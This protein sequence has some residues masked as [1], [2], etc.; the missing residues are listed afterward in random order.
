MSYRLT[1]GT[2]LEDVGGTAVI[3]SGD[4]DTAVLN[5]SAN[6]ML[7]TLLSCES[8]EIAINNLS[9]IYTTNRDTISLDLQSIVR[10]LTTRKMLEE[11]NT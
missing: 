10:D 4:G 1:L 5:E 7:S 6:A 2:V 11:Y 3:I 8:I 9:D